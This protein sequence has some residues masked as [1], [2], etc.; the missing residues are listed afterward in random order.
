MDAKNA[1]GEFLRARRGLVRPEDVG[2]STSGARRVK[3][4]RREEVAILAGISTDYYVRLEQGRDRSPSTQVLAAITQALNLDRD[5]ADYMIGLIRTQEVRGSAQAR[6]RGRAPEQDR[7]PPG[8]R[9]LID[10]WTGNPAWVQNTFFDIL[11][12]NALAVALSPNYAVG[13]NLLWAAFLDPSEREQRRD[14]EKMTR[15]GVAALRALAG[16]NVENP[17]LTQLVGELSVR[18]DRF[19]ELW[20]RHEVTHHKGHVSRLRHPQVGD[21]ELRSHKLAIG[22]SDGLTLVVLHPEP[23]SRSAELLQL[24]GNLSASE[25]TA[26]QESVGTQSDGHGDG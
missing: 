22:D 4:L 2:I 17:R 10:G 24:L 21:L 3:G 16:P 25:S 20:A 18:S 26:F 7:L 11:A 1:L 23:G 15:E 6:A 8:I 12:T 9:E 19:R 5:A 13:S 14:W